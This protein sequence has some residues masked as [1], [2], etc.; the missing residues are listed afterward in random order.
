MKRREV[1]LTMGTVAA[2][3]M[4]GTIGG[5]ASA[6]QA[7]SG[8]AHGFHARMKAKPGQGD[9]LVALLFEAPAFEHSDCKVFLIGRSNSDPDVVFVTEGWVSEAAHTRFTA[10]EEATSYTA[11]FG[12]L[13]EEWTSSDEIPV[14]GK[15]VLT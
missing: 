4:A 11:R 10:T 9:A 1:L 13:V 5:G 15:A 3:A 12:P 6:R 2:I 14:G 7:A 8:I